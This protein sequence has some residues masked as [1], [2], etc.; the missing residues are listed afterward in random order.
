[1]TTDAVLAGAWHQPSAGRLVLIFANASDRLVT[2][3]VIYD[4]TEYGLAGDVHLTEIAPR[5]R[6][7]TETVPSRFQRK[8]AIQPQAVLAWELTN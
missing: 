1:M 3:R 8:L 5:G 6:S 4:A 7:T 2:T